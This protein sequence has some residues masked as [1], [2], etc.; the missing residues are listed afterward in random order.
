MRAAMR[1]ACV[2]ARSRQ[3]DLLKL[4]DTNALAFKDE[5]LLQLVVSLVQVLRRQVVKTF[6]HLCNGEGF[7]HSAAHH[8]APRAHSA[9]TQQT[10]NT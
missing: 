5:D 3:Q 7:A 1:A 6:K 2:R 8:Y 9:H 4:L 10:Q